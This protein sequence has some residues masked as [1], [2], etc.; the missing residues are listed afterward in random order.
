M[1]PH[2]TDEV[3]P[4]DERDLD[5]DLLDYLQTLTPLERLQRHESARQLVIALRA[6]GA[7]FHG[8]DTRSAAEA[9]DEQR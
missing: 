2:N 4:P 5:V 9:V 1:A 6:A 8:F 7:K 3:P